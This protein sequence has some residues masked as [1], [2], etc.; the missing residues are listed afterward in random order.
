[1]ADDITQEVFLRYLKS[2]VSYRGVR[3]RNYLY[4]I[5]KNCIVD[6]YRYH[7][8]IVQ[9]LDDDDIEKNSSPSPAPA[10]DQVL[11]EAE[12]IEI[13]L[14]KIDKLSPQ[15]QEILFLRYRGGLKEKDIAEVVN[16]SYGNVR[17]I[18]SETIAQLSKEMEAYK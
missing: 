12:L 16:L 8:P 15:K 2:G 14:Q 7:R 5:A 13:M 11:E 1:M 9:I 18:L 6:W 4:T 10:P 17:R 3:L